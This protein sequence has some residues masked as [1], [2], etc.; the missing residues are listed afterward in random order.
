MIDNNDLYEFYNRFESKSYKDENEVQFWYAR[1]LQVILEY[2]NWKSF[3]KIIDK[4]KT[5]CKQIKS[6]V[7]FH[8]IDCNKKINNYK[9]SRYACYL[10]VQNADVRKRVVAFAQTYFAVQAR[11]QEMIYGSNTEQDISRNKGLKN[12][13]N[14]LDHM[15][16]EELA[17]NWFIITQ[18]EARLKRDNEYGKQ[19]TNNIHFEV[20]K[21]VRNT[22]V[23]KPEDLL[24]TKI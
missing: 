14:I 23:N 4:A 9:L 15:G 7:K 8:F 5:V 16:S 6:P 1:E 19:H 17:A 21:I 22:M 18:T 12:R 3:Q 20:G 11:K 13:C 24:V 2:K 10:I